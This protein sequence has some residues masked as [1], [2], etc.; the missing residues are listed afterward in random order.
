MNFELT[1]KI[2]MQI[3][4]LIPVYFLKT[5]PREVTVLIY[6]ANSL[7]FTHSILPIVGTVPTLNILREYTKTVRTH[8]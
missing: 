7:S 1:R 8:I 6:I 2:H 3:S 5:F 4:V